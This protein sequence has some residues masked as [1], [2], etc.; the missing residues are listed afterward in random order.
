[1]TDLTFIEEGNPSVIEGKINFKKR[2][3]IMEVILLLQQ[4]QLEPYKFQRIEPVYTFLR[5][6]PFLDEKELFMISTWF[7][8][9][10]K[11]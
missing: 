6:L 3:L 8:M 2:N 1:M 10:K 9:K 4:F 7:E 11:K 5:E